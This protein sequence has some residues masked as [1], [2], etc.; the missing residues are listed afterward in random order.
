MNNINCIN[1]NKN[2]IELSTLNLSDIFNNLI[3]FLPLVEFIEDKFKKYILDLSNNNIDLLNNIYSRNS[4]D[5][6]SYI[7]ENNNYSVI[8]NY[9]Y[10]INSGHINEQI[11]TDLSDIQYYSNK[12]NYTH[13]CFKSSILDNV[14][15]SV[16]NIVKFQECIFNDKFRIY[17]DYKDLKQYVIDSFKNQNIVDDDNSIWFCYNDLN[18]RELDIYKNNYIIVNLK[19]NPSNQLDFINIYETELTKFF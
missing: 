7:F 13:K 3:K 6:S 2:I 4:I 12:I 19:I 16:N 18:F 9:S 10:L 1:C 8:N 17:N 5:Y 14:N 11:Y 15:M